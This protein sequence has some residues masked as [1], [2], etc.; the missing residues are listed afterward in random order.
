MEDFFSRRP[1]NREKKKKNMLIVPMVSFNS[2]EVIEKGEAT[3][4]LS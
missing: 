1:K 4:Q 3:L 2:L